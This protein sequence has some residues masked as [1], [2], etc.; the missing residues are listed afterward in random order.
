MDH[1]DHTKNSD[2]HGSHHSEG[3]GYEQ[4]DVQIGGIIR[5]GVGLTVATIVVCL[6]MWGLFKY[7][8]AREAREEQALVPATRIAVD[9]P[10]R[11]AGPV[12][13]GAPGSK[14]ELKS[15]LMEMEEWLKV[16]QEQLNNS[17][18]VDRNAGITRIPIER[19]KELL[20]ERGLPFR[21]QTA[22]PKQETAPA[23][24]PATGSSQERPSEAKR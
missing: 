4:S 18:W 21:E 7:F 5:F 14:F 20:L 6:L 10:R 13:Q 24:P 2:A 19:A 16:E 22:T 8:E 17:G 23:E 1:A 11:P 9:Q 3:A 12:L 15:P